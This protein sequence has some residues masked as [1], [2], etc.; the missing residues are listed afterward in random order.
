VG[1]GAEADGPGDDDLRL[2][3]DSVGLATLDKDEELDEAPG[4]VGDDNWHSGLDWA[5]V[6]VSGGDGAGD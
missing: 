1:D 5:G 6:R 4:G 2:S 3:I